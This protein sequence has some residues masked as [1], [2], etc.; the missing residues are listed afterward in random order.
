M[1]LSAAGRAIRLGCQPAVVLVPLRR[2]RTAQVKQGEHTGS[3][4][5]IGD[6]SAQLNLAGVAF[7][8]KAGVI[9]IKLVG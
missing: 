8:I 4:T 7:A 5:I 6:G 3:S 1:K 9:K 2:H